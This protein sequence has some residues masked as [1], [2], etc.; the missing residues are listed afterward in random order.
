MFPHS[1]APM[2]FETEDKLVNAAVPRG[3]N[4]TSKFLG[5]VIFTSDF[6]NKTGRLELDKNIVYKI[7]LSYSPRVVYNPTKKL[8]FDSDTSWSTNFMFPPN[9]HIG[10]RENTSCNGNPGNQD[11][12]WNV[13]SMVWIN[14]MTVLFKEIQ[15][16][17]AKITSNGQKFQ[18]GDEIESWLPVI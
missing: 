15:V 13:S 1:A 4:K 16:Y 9:Q 18:C 5:G 12:C 3:A 8:S 17:V 7:R 11:G 2:P 10:P 6:T 14:V